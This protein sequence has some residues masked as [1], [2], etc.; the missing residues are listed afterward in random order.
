MS[1]LSENLPKTL[2]YFENYLGLRAASGY[3]FLTKEAEIL[4][5]VMAGVT[6]WIRSWRKNVNS[7]VKRE[8]K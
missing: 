8:K 5:S 1:G 4:H 6:G 3:Y 2:I 7:K